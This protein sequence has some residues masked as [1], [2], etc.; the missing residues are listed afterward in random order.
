MWYTSMPVK[1]AEAGSSG[2]TVWQI[3][4]DDLPRLT[5]RTFTGIVVAISGNVLISLALN[6]QKLA[7]KRVEEMRLDALKTTQRR[8]DKSLHFSTEQD[9]IKTD[10]PSLDEREEDGGEERGHA[11]IEEEDVFSDG[12]SATHAELRSL[13]SDMEP[14]I[15]NYGSRSTSPMRKGSKSDVK[16]SFISRLNPLRTRKKLAQVKYTLPVDIMSEDAALH[17]FTSE[18]RER[19]KDQALNEN[20]GEY[21]KSKL[22]W[23]SVTQF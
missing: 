20:E 1:L 18:R 9:L 14:L 21:L 10:D 19:T 8:E 6:L 4:M 13:T 5:T 17:G 23:A 2:W 12:P 16:R 22:W 15:P 3:I 11:D 7:H